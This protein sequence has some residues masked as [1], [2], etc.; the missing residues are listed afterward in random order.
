MTLSVFNPLFLPDCCI[1]T[2]F[3]CHLWYLYQVHN[4][5]SVVLYPFHV[6]VAIIGMESVVTLLI[7]AAHIQVEVTDVE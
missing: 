3:I 2:F 1:Q 6:V 4:K 5:L 7:L